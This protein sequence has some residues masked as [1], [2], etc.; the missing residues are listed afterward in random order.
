MSRQIWFNGAFMAPEDAKV[1]IFDRGLLFADS[2]Y[3]GFGILDG[4]IIDFDR[5]MARLSRSLGEIDMAMPMSPDAFFGMLMELVALNDLREGFVYLQITRGEA[6]RDYL[7]PGGLEP[8]MFAFT[9]PGHGNEADGEPTVMNLGSAPDIRWARRDI[10]STNLLGQVLAKRVA[11]ASGADEALMIDPEGYVTEGGAVSFFI[12]D[13]AGRLHARPL[14]GDL[15]PG[16]TRSTMLEVA[17]ELGVEVIA[18]KIT[19]DDVFAA[20][21]AFVT[22]SSTYVQPVGMVDGRAIGDGKPGPFTLKLRDAYL[23]A[24][25][26]SF[27]LRPDAT[28]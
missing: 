2:V 15:L 4:Q 5:H 13:D 17:D 6:E 24:V 27:R 28:S 25:R 14:N 22:G 21:E 1:S 18:D 11:D 7:F 10:K 26:A 20:R 8:N 19:L 12:I 3:E 23:K 16:I 9:Q